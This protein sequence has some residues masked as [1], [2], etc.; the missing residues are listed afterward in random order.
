MQRRGRGLGSEEVNSSTFKRG[1]CS[2]RSVG[3]EWNVTL[4]APEQRGAARA[5]DLGISC[6]YVRTVWLK[7]FLDSA[8]H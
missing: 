5:L 1:L 4:C 8:V 6:T 3:R 2:R 7:S